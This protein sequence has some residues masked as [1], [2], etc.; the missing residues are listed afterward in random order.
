MHY[1]HDNVFKQ[2]MSNLHVAQAM[3]KNH[4]PADIRQHFDLDT[5]ERCDTNFI[6]KDNKQVHSDTIYKA[7]YKDGGC[8]YI[9]LLW[10][11]QSSFDS[12]MP[13]RFLSYM[14]RIMESHVK[15]GGEA[16]PAVVPVLIYN[17]KASPY[18]GSND[19]FAAFDNK[20]L[21]RKILLSP[22]VLVDL[23]VMKDEN[24]IRDIWTACPN[25]LL[26]HMRSD[27]FLP[28]AL[29]LELSI[30]G[31]YKNGG[32]QFAKIM[33]DC[34]L[35]YT[36][37]SDEEA[38]IKLMLEASEEEGIMATLTEKWQDRGRQEGMQEGLQKGLKKG[39]A[40]G[41]AKGIEAGKAEATKDLHHKIVRNMTDRGIGM[42]EVSAV[43]GLPLNEVVAITQALD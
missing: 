36:N 35:D 24:L 31:L 22:F 2:T 21:A 10:E 27:D 11:H 17:G 42:D 5:L 9:Y 6:G 33:I 38:F 23:T 39:I 41:V 28:A 7:Q 12:H 29:Q 43:I 4:L 3:I 15:Q 40:R 18:P 13:L 32:K 30:A 34:I 8:G 20:E 26:K 37:I 1:R 14:C 25:M 16:L 19:F